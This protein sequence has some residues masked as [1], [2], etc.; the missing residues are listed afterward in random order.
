MKLAELFHPDRRK[1]A[2]LQEE[3]MTPEAALQSAFGLLTHGNEAVAAVISDC[4]DDTRGYYSGR[5]DILE[6]RG[7]RYSPE[8][9]PWLRVIAAVESCLANGFLTQLAP[10]GS[11]AAFAAEVRKVL[12]ASGIAF[13]PDKL[14]FDPQK[15]LAVWTGQFN[16]Y[17]GQ[18]GITLYFV[19]LYDGSN[20]MG[21]ARIADYAEA[22]E[23]AGF[24]GVIVTSRPG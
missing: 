17:A 21:A 7:L 10:D 2:P 6:R 12:A 24:A 15:S 19:E 18:S 23:M 14:V 22:A 1:S 9:E 3:P 8:T 4:L 20:V 13:S 5:E 11:P 16:E